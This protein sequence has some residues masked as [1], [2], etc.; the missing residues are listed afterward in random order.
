MVSTIDSLSAQKLPGGLYILGFGG[1]ARSVADIAVSVGWNSI[2]FIDPNV[3]DGERF[4]SYRT[5][6]E[7]PYPEPT[8]RFFPAAGDNIR[9]RAQIERPSA[10]WAT[11]ISPSARLGL[12]ANVGQATFVGHGAHIG[13][14]A[15]VGRGVI[16]NTQSIIEHEAVIGDYTHVS[17]NAV[18]AGRA[19]IGRSVF[20]GAGAVVIDSVSVC[21][22]VVIGAGA[23]VT[24]SIDEPGVYV[25]A[26]ARRVK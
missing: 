13:P 14:G 18:V 1:H 5:V 11:L 16:L 19:K 22:D 6:R 21:D 20:V 25:G 17:V 15:V 10:K 7:L 24:T 9:R 3:K 26:P 4:S 2:V 8:W 23:V 12:E